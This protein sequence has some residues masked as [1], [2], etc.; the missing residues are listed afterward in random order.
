MI[1]SCISI[2]INATIKNHCI[3][4]RLFAIAT[5]P[6][7]VFLCKTLKPQPMCLCK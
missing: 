6:R 2:F 4:Y 1:K 3:L 7:P 5:I